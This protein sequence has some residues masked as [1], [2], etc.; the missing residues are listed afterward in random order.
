MQRRFSLAAMVRQPKAQNK[1]AQNL[2]K[3]CSLDPTEH[4]ST[5]NRNM[6][7]ILNWWIARL[8]NRPPHLLETSG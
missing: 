3:P 8:C 1:S 7:L 2:P 5:W 4:P 6:G